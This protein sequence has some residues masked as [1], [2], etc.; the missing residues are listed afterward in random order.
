[1][2]LHYCRLEKFPSTF[3][4]LFLDAGVGLTPLPPVTY[5]RQ[6]HGMLTQARDKLGIPALQVCGTDS[7]RLKSY[8]RHWGIAHDCRLVLECSLALI[9]LNEMNNEHNSHQ[10]GVAASQNTVR[11]DSLS[12]PIKNSAAGGLS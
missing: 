1:M 10:C 5:P 12:G 2:H 7:R 11:Y 8:T 4:E 6:N 3:S 9:L